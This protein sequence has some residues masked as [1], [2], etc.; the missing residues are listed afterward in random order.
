[1]NSELNV[2]GSAVQQVAGCLII[3]IPG[4]ADENSIRK[5]GKKVLKQVE[6]KRVSGVIIDMSDVTILSSCEFVLLKNMAKAIAMMGTIP[7]F[8]GFK[9]GVAA[10]LVNLDTNFNDI[11]TARNTDDAFEI[12]A[13][14][15]AVPTVPK[16][17]KKR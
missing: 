16:G 4:Y 10:S 13:K 17:L 12:L 11:M 15:G 14:H 9:P 7:V 5:T 3:S 1:M 2:S 6:K 8:A